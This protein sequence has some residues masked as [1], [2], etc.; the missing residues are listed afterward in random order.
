[1]NKFKELFT[2]A[3]RKKVS[4]RNRNTDVNLGDPASVEKFIDSYID[5]NYSDTQLSS[6]AALKLHS[7][8]ARAIK[9]KKIKYMDEIVAMIDRKAQ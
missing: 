5:Q 1:M 2:E 3:K 7:D 8:I 6:Q 9:D 4:L